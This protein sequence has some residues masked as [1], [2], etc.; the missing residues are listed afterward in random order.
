MAAIRNPVVSLLLIVSFLLAAFTEPCPQASPSTEEYV[1]IVEKY[2][3]VISDQMRK[4]GITG[5][6][7]AL[8]TDK[9]VLWTEGFGCTDQTCQTQV[10]ED[11]PF[12]IQSMSK[13]MT[14]TAVLLAVEEGLLDLDIPISTYLP[15]FSVHSIFDEHPQDLITLRMLLSHNAGFT[16][17]APV[18]NNNDLDPGTWETHIASIS[19]T[20]LKYPVGQGYSYA[21]LGIDLAG[22]ILEQVAE[23]PFQQYVKIRLFE[24]LGM[25][26]STFDTGEIERQ[27]NRAIGQS[28]IFHHIPPITP[29]M[30][31]GGAFASANDIARYLQFHI[32]RGSVSGH[33]VLNS[34][35]IELMYRPHFQASEANNYGLGLNILQGQF[36]AK[37]VLHNGGGFGFMSQM[38][39][40]PDLKIGVV[41]LSNSQENE[42]D[43]FGW[44]SNAILD[45]VIDA[46]PDIY[47]KR[48]IANPFT[49]P[50][51]PSS[52]AML[53]QLE[54]IERI[55]QS[56]LEP[57][58]LQQ[59]RWK[60]YSGCYG[61]RKWGQSIL[62]VCARS[63]KQLEFNGYPVFEV[64]PGL[65]Y[66]LNGEVIDFRESI[67]TVSNN[68]LEKDNGTLLSQSILLRM[69]GIGFALAILWNAAEFTGRMIL[70]RKEKGMPPPR[71]HRLTAATR[72]AIT[73]ASLLGL[74]TFPM[75]FKFPILYFSGTPLPQEGM[76]IEMQLG[77]SM[78]YAVVG[79]TLLSLLGLTLSWG[80]GLDT[81]LNRILAC[82]FT[83]ILVLFSLLVVM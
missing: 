29:M 80:K 56:A 31:S 10:T 37:K 78:V 54:V 23:I 28:G 39:W 82:V 81:R 53:S 38:V 20:W 51:V 11:T 4:Q 7:I 33:P 24:P 13:S 22:F 61:I 14:A 49:P 27:L 40:Y 55:H 73:L 48:A 83:C 59:K 5:F 70:R 26:N 3:E 16:H 79:L 63:G 6:A 19:D 44:L 60:D 36:G 35:L 17:E 25:V 75:L 58:E 9:E 41:W 64:E 76:H 74:G 67:P 42:H 71:L 68:N 69:Y 18:G 43:L 34:Q 62:V 45:E 65:F 8:V 12:S 1:E 66:A 47:S 2:R 77:F 30:P 15:N 50:T 32:N 57:D 46:A 21:N 52:P 72:S